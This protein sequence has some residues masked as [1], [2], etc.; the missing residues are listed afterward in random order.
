MKMHICIR[1]AGKR[2]RCLLCGYRIK[3]GKLAGHRGVIGG[4]FYKFVRY[5]N[6]MYC[7]CRKHEDGDILE[8]MKARLTEKYRRQ[9]ERAE[10]QKK[11]PGRRQPLTREEL[12][13]I[14]VLLCQGE[15]DYLKIA[16]SLQRHPST[17]SRLFDRAGVK[18]ITA[19]DG[20]AK[21]V[22][23]FLRVLGLYGLQ[24][25]NTS[26]VGR[27]LGVNQTTVARHL[28]KLGL[29]SVG[30]GRQPRQNLRRRS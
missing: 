15:F 5:L 21:E 27:A 4:H 3:P 24:E 8:Y 11:I 28:P 25:I 22:D 13:R 18:P 29:K 16:A 9:L 19:R 1:M 6:V 30:R 23:D 14:I 7:F 17:I 10:K 2:H 12:I 20:R 26:H